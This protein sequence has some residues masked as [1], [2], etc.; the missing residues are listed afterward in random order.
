MTPSA[1]AAA[2]QYGEWFAHP[3]GHISSEA[4]QVR[5]ES[6]SM[7]ESFWQQVGLREL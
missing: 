1:L 4:E 3:L 6:V 2:A 5:D 7:I